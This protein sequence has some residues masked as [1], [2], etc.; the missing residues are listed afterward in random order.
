MLLDATKTVH[1]RGH[2]EI[3]TR[4]ENVRCWRSTHRQAALQ[5]AL[6]LSLSFCVCVIVFMIDAAMLEGVGD[7]GRVCCE[8][9]SFF[10]R[11]C[12]NFVASFRILGA[13]SP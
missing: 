10:Q 1:D 2:S 12:T 8:E 9:G 3:Q 11:E 4:Q 13:R 7:P 5:A 6:S